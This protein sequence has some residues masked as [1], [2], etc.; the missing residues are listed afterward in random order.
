[1]GCFSSKEKR[2]FLYDIVMAGEELLSD[3]KGLMSEVTT[4]LNSSSRKLAI[5]RKRAGKYQVFETI[6]GGRRLLGEFDEH[7]YAER[8]ARKELG[9]D[10]ADSEESSDTLASDSESSDEPETVIT[11]TDGEVT[12][13]ED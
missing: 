4:Q 11:A 7:K 2:K 3:K 8:F 1:M 10:V 13:K 6:S 12:D 5:V 9:D